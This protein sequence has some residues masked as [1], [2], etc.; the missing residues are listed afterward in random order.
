MM[1]AMTWMVLGK[2]LW[3]W[4]IFFV[5]I[6]FFIAF[7]LGVF[8]RKSEVI[9]VKQSLIMSGCYIA[10]GLAY[11]VFVWLY[12]GPQ[13]AEEYYT[14]FLLEK[15]LSIDNIFLISLIFSGLK[16]PRPY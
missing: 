4:A 15:S 16:I 7:D 10:L 1:D 5:I 12:L 9:G 3:V 8:H 14:G 6:L 2:P 11:G 13:S